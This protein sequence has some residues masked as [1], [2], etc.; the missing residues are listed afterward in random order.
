MKTILIIR[1]PNS[2]NLSNLDAELLADSFENKIKEYCICY[3]LFG[4][5]ETDK[6]TFEI[7]RL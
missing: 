1:P 7:I 2:Y 4:E 5:N 6:T 3:V